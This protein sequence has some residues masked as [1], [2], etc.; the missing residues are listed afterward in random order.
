MQRQFAIR[1]VAAGVGLLV[2]SGTAPAQTQAYTNAPIDIYAAPDYPIVAEVQEGSELT[3]LGCV[4]D[5]SWCDVAAPGLRGWAYGGYLS[6]PYQGTEVPVMTY[7]ATIGMPIVAFSI[8]SY[9]GRHYRDRP[10]YHDEERWANHP[11]PERGVRP[12]E[13]RDIDRP[14]V[15]RPEEREAPTY[16]RAPGVAPPPVRG[17]PPQG[18]PQPRYARP[19]EQ[20][21]PRAVEPQ[22]QPRPQVQPQP[23]VGRGV[24][25][26]EPPSR[27]TGGPQMRPGPAPGV[28]AA[29]GGRFEERGV[30]AGG[31]G[32]ER[33][34]APGQS[35]H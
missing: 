1:A 17:G 19:M 15:P 9:W 28:M 23:P 16:G 26:G 27:A 8:D 20:P 18:E 6:Y 5:Y 24:Q 12:P 7:G 31:R 21:S 13:R 30:Q 11:R 25:A 35:N 3:V 10:W 14:P 22:P 29:P 32:G 33:Q 34:E 4:E 2:L